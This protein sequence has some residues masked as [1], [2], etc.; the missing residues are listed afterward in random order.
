MSEPDRSLKNTIV[1]FLA[2]AHL[3]VEEIAVSYAKTPDLR[4]NSGLPDETLL[5]IKSKEDDPDF[6]AW[7]DSELESGK[8]VHYSKSTDYWN[9][10][11]GL[12]TD[13]IKQLKQI[14]PDRERLRTLWIDCSGF[15]SDLLETRLQATLY[16]TRNLFCI[17][18]PNVV[19]CFYF[20]NSSFFKHRLELDG[21]VISR[22]GDAR[23][24]LNDHSPHFSRIKDSGFCKAFK[25]AIYYPQQF[26]QD[27]D[28]M[29]NDSSEQRGDEHKTLDYLRKKYQISEMHTF[30]LNML[31]GV[32]RVSKSY[33]G[34][35]TNR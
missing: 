29:F 9:R 33:Q 14:D 28:F 6:M 35:A 1:A 7:L 16:G 11:D 8:L 34:P 30:D 27:P 31:A 18:R 5:E 22:N 26:S 19:T 25:D 32:M 12:I 13:G 24:N 21:V 4:I 23:L 17:G 3:S 2:D 15:H 10:L 20:E